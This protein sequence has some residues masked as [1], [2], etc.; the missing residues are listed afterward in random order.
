MTMI[1]QNK[2]NS[3]LNSGCII[4]IISSTILIFTILFLVILYAQPS[5][6]YDESDSKSDFEITVTAKSNKLTEESK[7][8]YQLFLL[9]FIISSIGI[10]VLSIILLIINKYRLL[11]SIINLILSI[12]TYPIIVYLFNNCCF[13]MLILVPFLYTIGSIFCVIG[14]SIEKRDN[15]YLV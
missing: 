14:G 1:N 13:I 10:F 5:P 12:A 3:L 7:S 11:L 2:K 15:K 4:N 8:I 9:L 6:K